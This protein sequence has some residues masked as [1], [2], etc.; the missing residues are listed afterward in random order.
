MAKVCDFYPI[1]HICLRIDRVS[2]SQVPPIGPC[3][4]HIL[5]L[6]FN[7][8]IVD[9]PVIAWVRCHCPTLSAQVTGFPLSPLD[10]VCVNALL[11]HHLVGGGGNG[12]LTG[13]ASCPIQEVQQNPPTSSNLESSNTMGRTME[14]Q[15]CWPKN[16]HCLLVAGVYACLWW[17]LLLECVSGPWTRGHSLGVVSLL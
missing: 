9:R 10:F 13:L 16:R 6:P 15:C 17:M 7:K 12:L 1:V 11:F 3:D 14:F 2:S 4:W 5:T 8:G